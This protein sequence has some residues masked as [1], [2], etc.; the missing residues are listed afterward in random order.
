MKPPIPMRVS[1]PVFYFP[2]SELLLIRGGIRRLASGARRGG[3]DLACVVYPTPIGPI[4]RRPPGESEA[5]DCRTA[6]AAIR[7]N[8]PPHCAVLQEYSH[9]TFVMTWP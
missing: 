4:V 9:C 8:C 2:K 6:H 5:R 3:G 7:F 1:N